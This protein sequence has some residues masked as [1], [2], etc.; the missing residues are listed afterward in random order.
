MGPRLTLPIHFLVECVFEFPRA[1]KQV[2]SIA[3]S[4]A[5]KWQDSVEVSSG[6][7]QRHTLAGIDTFN[8]MIMYYN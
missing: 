2:I 5:I 4:V 1:Q 7:C 3:Q 6:W 8:I